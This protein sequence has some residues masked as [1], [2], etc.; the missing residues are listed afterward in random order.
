MTFELAIHPEA[1]AEWAL[2]DE[3]IKRRFKQK[4]IKDLLL[5]SR[6]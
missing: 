3:S 4:R 2:L 6:Q 5:N 1:E